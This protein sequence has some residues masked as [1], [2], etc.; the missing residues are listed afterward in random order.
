[1]PITLVADRQYT[2]PSAADGVSIT[3]VSTAWTNS[4]Y[5]TVLAATPSACV[6]TG[7]VVH[8]ADGASST[9]S[10][11]AEIDIATGTAGAE[12]VIATFR[13][14]NRR[15]VNAQWGPQTGLLLPIGI[16]N[17]AAGVRVA[18]RLRKNST[19]TTAWTVA[20]TYLQKPL[21]G[22]YLTTANVLKALPPAAAGVTVTAG[23]SAWASGSWAQL[24]TASGAA[25]V[26]VGVVFGAPS[27][28]AE[29]ELDLGTGAASSETVITTLR[30][31]TGT[32]AAP[33]VVLLQL[34]L[35]NVAASIRLAARL[36][37][38]TAS[39]T[40]IVSLLVLELPL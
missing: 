21:T 13:L 26:I 34:P 9:V 25:L 3:P 2:A 29:Y 27:A 19:S 32:S 7:L 39:A 33:A 5:V 6:L 1:V 14:Y 16:D 22:T 10:Y 30:C 38:S 37:C 17:L 4:A 18:A 23:G 11:D 20:I 31:T 35:D 8:T 24:R 12:V 36:R 40:L 28:G 15:I